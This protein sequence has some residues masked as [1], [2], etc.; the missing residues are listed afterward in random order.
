MCRRAASVSRQFKRHGDPAGPLIVIVRQASSTAA[1]W[2]D[3]NS[4]GLPLARYL[5]PSG[6]SAQLPRIDGAA[7]EGAI[8]ALSV[9]FRPRLCR[10]SSR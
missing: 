2:V 6:T 3:A 8:E 5:R 9:D 4:I 10:V 1:D 7:I